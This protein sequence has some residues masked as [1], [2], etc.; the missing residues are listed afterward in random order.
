M[1]LSTLL[2]VIQNNI[3]EKENFKD[4]NITNLALDYRKVTSNSLFLCIK[5]EEFFRNSYSTTSIK[6][7]K[8]Y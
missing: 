5:E 3:L 1:K 2:K 7:S 4:H 6:L 8:S